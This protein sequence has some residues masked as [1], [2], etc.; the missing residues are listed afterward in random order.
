MSKKI[1]S[2]MLALTTIVWM[3]GIT[4]ILP[5]QAAVTVNEGDLIR[6]PDGIKVYIVNDKGY[7]RHIFNPAVFD[8][9]GHFSWDSIK[10]VSQDVLDS[11]TSSDMYRADGD[12]K[13]YSLEEVDEASGNAIKHW[14]DMTAAEFVAEGYSWD[15]VFIVNAVEKDY[16]STGDPLTVGGGT[17]PPVAGALSV[18]AGDME[19]TMA[20]P[21]YASGVEVLEFDLTA[22][23]ATTVDELTLERGG[24][25]AYSDFEY[26]YIYDGSNRLTNGKSISSDSDT[27]TFTNLGIDLEAGETKTLTVK[28]DMDTSG[29]G[30]GN[31][32]YFELTSVEISDG[33]VTGLPIAGPTIN[34]AS[35]SAAILTIATGG[36]PTNPAIGA[37]QAVLAKLRIHAIANEK[38]KLHQV[39]LTNSGSVDL[40]NIEN[41]K[42]YK[43]SDV[44]A[45][46]EVS[47][48]HIN[49]VLDEP[50]LMEKGASR[51]FDVKGDVTA[52]NKTSETIKL[53]LE[54]TTDLLCVGQSYGYGAALLESDGTTGN[55]FTSSTGSTSLTLQGGDLTVAFNGP[56]TATIAKGAE[57]VNFFEFSLTA[58]Q[59]VT[60]R[61]LYANVYTAAA[62]DIDNN[63]VTDIKIVDTDTG[64]TVLGPVDISSYTDNSSYA[65]YTYTEDFDLDAGVTRNFKVTADI[66][67]S[68]SAGT[69]YFKLGSVANN[70]VFG[71]TDVKSRDVSGEYIVAPNIIPSTPIQGR[72]MTVG[73]AAL[74]IALAST[75]VS[76][77]Y[78][79]GAQEVESVGFLL[80]AGSGSDIKVT[81]IK[82]TASVDNVTT[83]DGTY[84]TGVEGGVYAYEL[85]SSVSLWD[86]TT[87]LGTAENFNSSGEATFDS[88][89]LD[90]PAGTTKKLIVKGNVASTAPDEGSTDRIKVDIAD[91][92]GDISAEDE[93][94][95]TVTVTDT[96]AADTDYP[97]GG[98]ATAATVATTISASGKLY[99]YPASDKPVSAIVIAGAEDVAFSKFKFTAV[100]EA[101]NVKEVTFTNASSSAEGDYDDAISDVTVSYPDINGDTKTASGSLSSGKVTVTLPSSAYFYVP[102][103]GDAYLTVYADMSAIDQTTS[104]DAPGLNLTRKATDGDF[105]AI[106]VSSGT[107]LEDT[108]ASL[109]IDGSAADDSCAGNAMYIRKAKPTIT[110]PTTAPA[111]FNNATQQTLYRFRV[112]ADSAGG[113]VDLYKLIFN[114][115]T[116]GAV[117]LSSYD[118]YN[119]TESTYDNWACTISGASLT[120]TASS[121]DE[122][123]AGGY[124]DFKLTAT[125]AS[126]DTDDYISVYL[127]DDDGTGAVANAAAGSVASTPMVVWSD[128]SAVPHSTTSSDWTNGYLV[129]DADAYNAA[130]TTYYPITS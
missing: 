117:N 45:T 40:P 62:G 24:V 120:C 77:T 106:G 65:S 22:D 80:A 123:A 81:S 13:V 36:T 49:F 72:N 44:L 94:G 61:N 111:T 59:N 114:V 124:E 87:Q 11:Y 29:A 14:L 3:T 78:V 27:V 7:K 76:D 21:L 126:A 71:D 39:T 119:V 122:I 26:V 89:T 66:N 48:D 121:G 68:A 8:M 57:D 31:I 50:Y 25:G 1:I 58:K 69:Y 56:S 100:D 18:T 33:S 96:S 47:G 28:V 20:V 113:A 86:G 103:D 115:T 127:N 42:L 74:T 37:E 38:V 41:W 125:S 109:Y 91:I 95:N 53:Y 90:I 10:D 104:G 67:S 75:P 88:F 107:T 108:S 35:S 32:N 5:A 30:S 97:N 54:E 51:Y 43:G 83:S 99:I 15:G 23:G 52:S 34:I 16:Y 129:K 130:Q 9:Y 46:G 92:S 105:E 98:S 73:S 116:S 63:Y 85:F 64:N 2:A 110:N 79:K 101:M 118:L 102:K 60:V 6:G 70:N 12:A 19:S 55:L 112:S 17:T 82:T 93:S 128:E 84:A 4:L